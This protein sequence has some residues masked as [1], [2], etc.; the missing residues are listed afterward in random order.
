MAGRPSRESLAER[1]VETALDEAER[2]GWQALRLHRV[3][4][5]LDLSLAELYRNFADADAIAE[6]WLSRADRAMLAR[7]GRAFARRAPAVRLEETLLAWLD[8][9]SG[10]RALTR[11]ILR[12]KLYPGHPHHLTS[13]VFR[14]S[15]TVQWW[16]EAAL[17]DDGPPRRQ[18]EEIA[19]TWLFVATVGVWAN[20]ASP[21]Q[22]AT[23]RFLKRAL[24]A[25]NAL[26][27]R[28]L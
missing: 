12:D 21:G 19:L 22:Q 7:R 11:S 15:R 26:A 27:A 16:R 6:A 14:L 24:G 18:I 2:V 20:D 9:L 5:R 3:A 8:A 10:H 23:R 1:I 25:A 13:L 17:L 4:E 28:Y